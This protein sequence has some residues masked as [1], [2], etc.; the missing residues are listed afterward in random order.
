MKYAIITLNG[1]QYRVSEGDEIV[2]DHLSEK[3]GQTLKITDINMIGEGEKSEVGAP[4]VKNGLVSL[5]VTGE[6]RAPKIRVAT[7][8]AKS[9]SRK[10]RGH[11]QPT[12]TVKVVSISLK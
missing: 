7:Y 2:V 1:K 9:R 4:F 5:E 11:K 12:R 10:V 8:K 6:G 3:V